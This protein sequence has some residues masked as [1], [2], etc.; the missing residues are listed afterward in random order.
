MK[1]LEPLHHSTKQAGTFGKLLVVGLLIGASFFVGTKIPQRPVPQIVNDLPQVLGKQTSSINTIDGKVQ[2]ALDSGINSAQDA[3]TSTGNEM[4]N[5]ISG[6][7]ASVANS[8]T[9]E[10]SKVVVEQT[11]KQIVSQIEKLPEQ[12]QKIIKDTVCK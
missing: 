9:Q 12:D 10:V 8:L 4:K 5:S 1:P 11:A 7:A 3:L 6:L 2:N